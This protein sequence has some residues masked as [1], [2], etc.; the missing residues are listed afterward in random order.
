MVMEENK[1]KRQ[2]KALLRGNYS[3]PGDDV[4]PEVP[5][6]LG[7]WDP[8]YPKN[9]LGLARWLTSPDNP[10]FARVTIN[11][12]W[13]MLFGV[14]LVK[15]TEDFGIQ[16]ESPS[17]PRLLDHLAL[18]LIES[19]WDLRF[20]LEKVV[21][22]ATYRQSS[23]ERDDIDDP[24][25]R[26][27]AR[28]PRF[29]L[30]AETIRDQALFV[31]GLLADKLGGP[32]VMVYQPEG[33]WLDLG[34]R[35]GFTRAH[36]VGDR[37]DVHRRSMYV[38]AK[39]AMP[40]PVLS[41]FDTPSRDVCVVK[42]QSTNTPL[43]ALVLRHE[44]GFVESARVF[45]ERLMTMDEA[46][47]DQLQR[48]WLM[49]L[50][51]RPEAAEIAVMRKLRADRL[52]YFGGHPQVRDALLALGKQPRNEELDELELAALTEVCRVLFNLDETVTRE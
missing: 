5:G 29:R 40:N 7:G 37:E 20:V 47:E 13:Q 32:S 31:S 8:A 21:L 1:E 22:S 43:Q 10:L 39:R 25:N 17:H 11:R 12:Y 28:G 33:L 41:T 36:I 2:T 48:A 44:L 23:I 9:R 30:P 27:L 38:Y 52:E 24:D 14:G 50:S 16:G 34:D 3:T 45:A 6:L 35:D 51:R 46:F 49:L 4:F 26:L 42:R 19:G 15:T 18:D